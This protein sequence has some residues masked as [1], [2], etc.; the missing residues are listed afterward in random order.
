MTK[1]ERKADAR[2]A[3]NA[4]MKFYPFTLDDLSGEQWRWIPNYEN[5]Y[6][7][8]T[9]GRTKSFHRGK[10][11]ILRPKVDNDG[12]LCVHLFRNGKGKMFRVNRLVAQIFIANEE[13]K[14]EVD[15]AYA[16]K[17]DNYFENLRWATSLENK[18]FAEEIGRGNAKGSDD[19]QAKLTNAQVEYIRNYPDNLTHPQ[20]AKRF[21][22]SPS[23]IRLAQI[24]QS[25]KHANGT[26]TNVRKNKART[27]LTDDE[28]EQIRNEY[29]KG[30]AFSGSTALARR[31]NCSHRTILRIVNEK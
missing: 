26:L 31:Y 6:Q 20:L 14:P 17:L 3:Y 24:G 28:R 18:K 2:A 29:T 9:F 23:T 22:V 30:S 5:L 13:A 8:S 7:E 21:N 11:I 12:Y 25:Y 19:S 27:I 4:L 1:A 10:T 15:H 16:V